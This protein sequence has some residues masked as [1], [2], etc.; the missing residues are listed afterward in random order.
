[1]IY[2]GEK[3]NSNMVADT[4]NERTVQRIRDYEEQGHKHMYLYFLLFLN[5]K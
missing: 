5:T 4:K 1:M 2:I 3:H